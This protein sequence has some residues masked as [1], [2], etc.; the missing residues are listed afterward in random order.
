V[1]LRRRDRRGDPLD[2]ARELLAES[3]AR[4]ELDGEEHRERRELQRHT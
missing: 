3:Y 2:R 4:G 1:I